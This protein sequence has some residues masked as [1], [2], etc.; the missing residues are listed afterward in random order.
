MPQACSRIGHNGH[1]VEYYSERLLCDVKLN[2]VSCIWLLPPAASGQQRVRY[3]GAALYIASVPQT[4]KALLVFP[5]EVDDLLLH[6][7]CVLVFDVGEEYSSSVRMVDRIDSEYRLPTLFRQNVFDAFSFVPVS[8]ADDMLSERA[9]EALAIRSC[10]SSNGSNNASCSQRLVP[11]ACS[12]IGHDGHLLGYYSERLLCDVKL[13]IV[14]C[15]WLLPPAT[16]GQQQVRCSGAAFYTAS[17]PQTYKALL[18]FP[19]EVDDLLL[20]CG[21]VLVFDVGEEYSSSVRMLDRIS[22]GVS[23]K[24]PTR[25]L[26]ILMIVA[27]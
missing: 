10:F 12:R 27:V 24:E 6:C 16:S 17:V 5:A 8:P 13:N 20:H 2:I 22:F 1:L 9:E 18:V 7:G 19:A 14:S 25:R 23:W 4:C 15:I 11:Q 3:S 26:P 21:C